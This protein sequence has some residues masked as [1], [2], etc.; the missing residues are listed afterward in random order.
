MVLKDNFTCLTKKDWFLKY[1]FYLWERKNWSGGWSFG[2]KVFWGQVGSVSGKWFNYKIIWNYS[3]I[4][5]F[6]IIQSFF[7][8]FKCN[9][10]LNFIFFWKHGLLA[11]L[12]SEDTSKLSGI[13]LNT[14]TDTN[15]ELGYSN[16][17]KN[18]LVG[19]LCFLLQTKKN[20]SATV[21][22]SSGTFCKLLKKIN[23]WVLIQFPS[24]TIGILPIFYFATLGV[25]KWIDVIKLSKA[26]NSW[27]LGKIPK[28]WGIAMNPV[29]H[30]HGGRTNGGIHPKTP[31][32]FLTKNVKTWKWKLWSNSI[33]F[34]LWK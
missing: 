14:I 30:P 28:V 21:S 18:F 3:I 32:G 19:S 6:G 20:S 9:F 33:I 1:F 25:S 17:I 8:P 5:L 27:I 24:K 10:V 4:N 2:K 11:L 23:N 34:S 13:Y 29:D 7:K 16:L 12:P 15:I 26:G 31:K 22:R